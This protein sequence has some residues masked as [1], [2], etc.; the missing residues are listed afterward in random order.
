MLTTADGTAQAVYEMGWKVLVSE[1]IEFITSDHP[2]AMFDPTPPFPWTGS[3]WLSSEN[4]ETT[5][6]LTPR[7]CL[8]VVPRGARMSKEEVARDRVEE[9]NLRTYGFAQRHL[10]AQHQESLTHLRRTAKRRPARVA[11]PRPN[12]QVVMEEADPSDPNAGA[13]NLKRGWP[14]FLQAPGPDGR[15]KV[16]DY[17]VMGYP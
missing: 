7:S 1:E 13:A 8:L 6:P 5:F 12:Y 15:I 2:L 16:L 17:K 9:I 11:R 14:R 4:A 3:A 10:F